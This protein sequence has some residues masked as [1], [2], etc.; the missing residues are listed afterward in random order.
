MLPKADYGHRYSLWK[1]LIS[2]KGGKILRWSDKFD[3]S[4]LAK[5]S[6]GYT[7]GSIAHAVAATLT[8]SRL[9]QQGVKPLRPVE[10]IPALSTREPVY[11]EEEEMYSSWYGK[12]PAGKRRS[13]YVEGDEEEKGKKGGG[14]SGP[15][16]EKKK[17]AKKKK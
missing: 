7:A 1:E 4:A 2:A 17:A 3:L 6:E 16:K 15:K 8:E 9:M 10:F 12:T 5:I 13:R 14:A 11:R